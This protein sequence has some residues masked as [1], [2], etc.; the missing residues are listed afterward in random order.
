VG[1]EHHAPEDVARRYRHETPARCLEHDFLTALRILRAAAPD[2]THFL[3][4]E[5]DCRVAQHEWDG[6]V[7]DEAFFLDDK[8][9]MAGSIV[10]HNMSCVSMDWTR[11]WTRFITQHRTSRFPI[12]CYG[13]SGASESAVPCMFINGALGI[14]DLALMLKFFAP[15]LIDGQTIV[16]AEEMAAWD[17]AIAGTSTTT[18]R[19]QSSTGA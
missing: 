16:A 13:G 3:Y 11:R 6:I 4:L 19:K 5:S 7:F 12:P 1:R 9:L 18:S 8:P 10:C 2:T 15:Q 14:Y 17:V